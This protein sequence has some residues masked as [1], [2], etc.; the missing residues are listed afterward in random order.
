[1][2]THKPQIRA[3]MI[4]VAT[5][6]VVDLRHMF[7]AVMKV[8]GLPQIF[9]ASSPKT[10]PRGVARTAQLGLIFLVLLPLHMQH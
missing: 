7:A 5:A 3:Q 2:R 9:R 8:M 4:A 6:H 10:A 1:M